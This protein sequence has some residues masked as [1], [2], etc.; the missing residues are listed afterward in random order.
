LT[1]NIIVLAIG[2]TGSSLERLNAFLGLRLTL[3]HLKASYGKPLRKPARG[4]RDLLLASA[5]HG[6]N[7]FQR[8]DR[9]RAP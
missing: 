8:I 6:K 9:T 1:H 3:D 7:C 5:I 2:W 4:L